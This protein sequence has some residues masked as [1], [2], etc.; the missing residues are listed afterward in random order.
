MLIME[1]TLL[2]A[3]AMA[4]KSDGRS[5]RGDWMLQL[6][7]ILAFLHPLLPDIFEI[8]YLSLYVIAIVL[9]DLVIMIFSVIVVKSIMA[10]IVQ[11]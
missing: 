5:V 10:I 11:S 1:L 4:S 6:K 9:R 2:V 7:G 3:L 8:I